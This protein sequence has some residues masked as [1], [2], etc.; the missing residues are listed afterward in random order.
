M[1]QRIKDKVRLKTVISVI[2]TILFLVFLYYMMIKT[3]TGTVKSTVEGTE[4]SLKG[5]TTLSDSFEEVLQDNI[6]EK[7]SY[8]DLNG[9][10]VKVLGINSLNERQKLANGYLST[11]EGIR[12]VST[13]IEN[14]VELNEFL[15][16]RGIDFLY[17][18]APSVASMYDAEFA[19]GYSSESWQNIDTMIEALSE[20]GV[21]TIDMDSWFEENGWSTEDV[22]FVTDHHWKPEAAFAATNESLLF[23]EENF[24]IEYDDSMANYDIWTIDNYA[25]SY[26]GSHGKRVGTNYA[27]VDD[28]Q[29]IYR[30]DQSE[31]ELSYLTKGTTNW[32]YRNS[33]FDMAK[34]EKVDY[35]NLS[36]YHSYIG[37]DYPIVNIKNENAL[38]DLK[39]IVVG[40]SFRLPV[41]TFLS[42]Y[43][44]EL[45]H[46]DL[47]H[48]TDGTFA[49]YVEEIQPDI[50]LMCTYEADLSTKS[51]YEFGTAAYISC[52]EEQSEV[53]DVVDIGDI[54]IEQSMDNNN[55]FT[56]V[57]SNLEPGQTYTLTVDTTSISGGADSYVQM[58]LQ[59]LSTNKAVYNRYFEADSDETQ[60]WIFTVPEDSSDTYSIYLYAG[61][62]GHTKEV[63]VEVTDIK[64]RKGIYEE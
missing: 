54:S 22:F 38:N 26:L 52:I 20:A 43:F 63:S 57:Y 37:G 5:F 48:Y 10:T 34:L 32:T 18:L 1:L 40:D 6:Y 58:T 33:V 23:M 16:E 35:Y 39:I 29:V 44:S 27:G 25:S 9:L 30:E 28:V 56:V 36:P 17:V 3:Y 14:T 50:V 62:K 31:V 4:V 2:P 8:L 59:D 60:K 13:S 12:D 46:I 55:N 11:F 15:T 47:R 51:I 7:N 53:L 42:S 19:P 21:N 45:Y 49:Q 61:T 41:E 64:L 24:G